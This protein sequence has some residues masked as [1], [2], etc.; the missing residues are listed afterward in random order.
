VPLRTVDPGAGSDAS[1]LRALLAMIGTARVVA[2]GEPTH[3]AHEPLAFRNRLFRFLVEHAGVTAI[4]IESGLS[5]SRRVHDFVLEGKEGSGAPDAARQVVKEGLTW[6]FGAYAENVELVRW[7][8]DYNANPAHSRKL[9][10]YGIDLSAGADGDFG[11]ARIAVDDALGYLAR[12]DSVSARRIQERLG[13]YLE[14]FSSARYPTL[15]R[16]GRDTVSAGIADLA[17]VLARGRRAFIAATSV[18]DYEWAL[19]NAVV[20]RQLDAFFRVTPPPMPDGSLSPDLYRGL[21]IRDSAMAANV[22]WVLEREGPGSRIVVFA[23]NGHVMNAA[24]EGPLW[25]VFPRTT[26]AMGRHLRKALGDDLFI[27]GTSSA[28]NGAGLPNAPLDPNGLD[29]ALARVGEPLFLLDLRPARADRAVSAW[30][31]AR[32]SLRLNFDTYQ[33]LSPDTAF[34]AVAF[35]DTLTKS[36]R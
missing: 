35:I 21:D 34:D 31:G 11:R 29:A 2:I 10:F 28:H 20:A 19:R 22:R 14:R 23:H 36:G 30:L 27:I 16:K 1:D 9:G 4:A 26:T 6:G 12:A 7:M 18:E 24:A 25:K 15:T 8:R 17:A 5:E 3:G 32:R 33:T 13:P